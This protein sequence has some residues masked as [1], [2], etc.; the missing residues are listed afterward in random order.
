MDRRSAEPGQFLLVVPQGGGHRQPGGF[1]QVA[2]HTGTVALTA[3]V[4]RHDVLRM[5]GEQRLPERRARRLG[6]LL[7]FLVTCASSYAE[8]FRLLRDAR[9]EGVDLGGEVAHLFA[10]CVHRGR[11]EVPLLGGRSVVDTPGQFDMA[12]GVRR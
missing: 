6:D 7:Q 2:G 3:P 10:C 12:T 4:G 11:F 8:P 9:N 5:G 1:Q